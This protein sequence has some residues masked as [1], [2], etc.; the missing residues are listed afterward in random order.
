M[1]IRRLGQILVDL[2]YITDEQLDML[3]AEQRRKSGEML[4]KLAE[5]LG[6]ITDEQLAENKTKSKE[7]T[8]DPHSHARI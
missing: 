2:G 5:S 7:N 8:S 3:L 4:G 6:L 1:A